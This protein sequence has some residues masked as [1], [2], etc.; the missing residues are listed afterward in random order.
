MPSDLLVDG[1]VEILERTMI[2]RWM[3]QWFQVVSWYYTVL[4]R[5]DVTFEQ[6]FSGPVVETS[7]KV[8]AG[9]S[10]TELKRFGL[11]WQVFDRIS[12]R[13]IWYIPPILPESLDHYCG[14]LLVGCSGH[15][16][17]MSPVGQTTRMTK[18]GPVDFL[19]G[20]YQPSKRVFAGTVRIMTESGPKDHLLWFWR[21]ADNA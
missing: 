19:E 11:M 5:D 17:L 7:W 18:T 12:G 13:G 3:A 21:F 20:V 9:D 6:I 4:M 2:R 15:D 14:Y 16:G 10:D 8:R 1:E